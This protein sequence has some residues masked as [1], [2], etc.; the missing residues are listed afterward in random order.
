[1]LALLACLALDGR[2]S[3]ARLAA[4]LWGQTDEAGAT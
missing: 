2:S 1:V 3:R 4:T